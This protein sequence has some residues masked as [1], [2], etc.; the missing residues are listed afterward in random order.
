MSD[1]G[2]NEWIYTNLLQEENIKNSISTIAH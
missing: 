2:L 1:K